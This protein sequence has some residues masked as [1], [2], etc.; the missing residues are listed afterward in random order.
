MAKK[1]KEEKLARKAKKAAKAAK[2]AKKQA[3][4]ERKQERQE[5]RSKRERRK[6]ERPSNAITPG[7]RRDSSSF[8]DDYIFKLP[9]P[10]AA[11]IYD[12]PGIIKDHMKKFNT[13]NETVTDLIRHADD[14]VRR[15]TWSDTYD[16]DGA[17]QWS[18]NSKRGTP[19]RK[20]ERKTFKQ[21]A[22]ETG[23][24]FERVKRK[25]READIHIQ[26]FKNNEKYFNRK[27][28]DEQW[29]Q[30]MQDGFGGAPGGLHH[31]KYRKKGGAAFSRVEA[32]RFNSRMSSG[33]KYGKNSQ[34]TL[35]H[36]IGHALG[37]RD[38]SSPEEQAQAANYS[39]MGYDSNYKL[40]GGKNR[41]GQSDIDAIIKN[42]GL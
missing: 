18:T 8:I 1:D 41:F 4:Q 9:V 38:L 40:A 39:V 26:R 35:S 42:F 19:E 2:R 22:K 10:E 7:T 15:T 20:Q 29:M 36:E 25:K 6:Q 34:Q 3:R 30:A 12:E 21:L 5:L 16:D 17:I 31:N 32:P 14:N 28:G 13:G 33:E 23:L 11:R 37:L 27:Y 24:N